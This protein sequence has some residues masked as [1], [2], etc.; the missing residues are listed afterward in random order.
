MACPFFFPT[1]KTNAGWAFPSR[2]PLGTGYC[3]TC[4]AAGHEVTPTESELRDFCNLGYAAQCSRLPA[5]RHADCVRFVVAK[6]EGA[7]IALHYVIEREHAP[8]EHGELDFD[9]GQAAWLTK[10]EDLCL[11]RQAEVYLA[12]YLERRP[13]ANLLAADHAD[14]R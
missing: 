7:R 8:I 14:E 4:H 12:G 10:V 3:G 5:D 13:R 6:D 9:C 2:L 1:E 11:Q